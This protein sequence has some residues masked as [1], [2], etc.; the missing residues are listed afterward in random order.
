[1]NREELRE[2]VKNLPKSS[3]VY[4]MKDDS[5]T[6]IYV[7]KAKILRNR[8]KSYFDDSPKTQ[9][10]YALVSNIVDFEY[11]LTNS[12]LD[13][14][15]LESNLIHKHKPKYNILLKDDK[16]FPYLAINMRE[17]FPRVQIVRR[18]KK[19]AGVLLFGPYVTGTRVSS[20][21]EIIRS[22]FKVR[23]CNI[24]FDKKTGAMKPCLHGQ[25][26]NCV[27]PCMCGEG[28]QMYAKVI[29]DVIDFLNGK[30]SKVKALLKKRMDDFAAELKFEEALDCRQKLEMLDK[31]SSNLITSFD[32]TTNLDVFGMYKEDDA[33]SVCVN[34][35]MIRGGKNVGQANYLLPLADTSTDSEVLSTFIAQYYAEVTP[36]AEILI[37]DEELVEMISEF[38]LERHDK[39]VKVSVPKI[40]TKKQ[41]LLSVI[42]NAREYALK[43][44]DKLERKEKLTTGAMKELAE[45]LGLKSVSRIEGFDISN[46]SGVHNVSSMVVFVNGEPAKKEYRKFRI[47]SVEGPNDF[48]CMKETLTRRAK[49]ILENDPKFPRPDLIMIDGGLGQLHK[50]KEALDEV[51]VNIPMISLAEKNEEIYTL[52]S[53]KPIKL[54]KTNYALRLLIRVRDEAHRFAVAYYNNLHGKS[55]KSALLE[56]EGLGENRIK[57]LYDYFKT[58][59][60]ITSATPEEIAKVDGIGAKTAIAIYSH[61]HS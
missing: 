12:E 42:D 15:S 50:A 48:A 52:E 47:Q 6:I 59:E 17:K 41:L 28:A 9:K 3:G 24:N 23:T 19:K 56:I 36:P 26:G 60:N 8:V 49:K 2:K 14:F 13:A 35:A 38:L 57:K 46:I 11:I 39:K 7:G 44:S 20:L 58:I 45:I 16:S 55:L 40:G 29:D 34:V 31:M 25:I 18:P 37:A 27:A 54:P 1:M 32:T 5:G 30:T 43:N 22:A 61:I 21:I 51:G 4:I 10:T 53:N 33:E